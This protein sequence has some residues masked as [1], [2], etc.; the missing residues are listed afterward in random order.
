MNARKFFRSFTYAF[1]GLLM[2]CKQQNMKFHLASAVVVIIAAYATGVSTLEW[3]LLLIVIGIVISLEM[4]NTAIEAVVDLASPHI[5]PL[6][7]VAKDVAAGAV[8][9]FAGVSVIIGV[10]IFIPKWF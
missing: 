9:V 6:A 2:A 1:N 10:L 5:H 4:I 8:L 3:A 7:K